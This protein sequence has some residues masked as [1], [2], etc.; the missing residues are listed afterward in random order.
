MRRAASCDGAVS[1]RWYPRRPDL[2]DRQSAVRQRDLCGELTITVA[3]W[4]AASQSVERRPG[5]FAILPNVTDRSGPVDDDGTRSPLASEDELRAERLAIDVAAH[6]TVVAEVAGVAMY[7]RERLSS[8]IGRL[9]SE[10]EARLGPAVQELAFACAQLAANSDPTRPAVTWVEAPPHT[11]FNTT[12]PGGRYAADNPDTIYRQ[13]PIDGRSAYRLE[14]RFVGGRPA[15]SVYQAVAD[16]L[17]PSPVPGGQ[18]NGADLVVDPD[19]TFAITVGPDP[20]EGRVNHLTTSGSAAQLFLRDTLADWAAQATPELAVRRVSG[21]TLAE[22]A[23]LDDLVAKAVHDLRAAGRQ[24]IDFYILGILFEP[25]ANVAPPPVHGAGIYRSSGHF[26]LAAD[27][28]LLVTVHPAGAAYVSV[29]LY[30]VWSVSVSYWS[31]QTSLTGAQAVVGR[32][33][34][35]TF[36]VSAAET[37]V[38]NWLDTTGLERGTFLVRWQDAPFDREPGPSV[39]SRVVRVEDIA[40]A[41][42]PGTT[43]VDAEKRSQQRQDRQRAFTRRIATGAT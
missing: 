14:G 11:W 37:G 3:A 2:S 34:T 20:P 41:L 27:E 19:G 15:S 23:T 18:I 21:P 12:V 33:G 31:R 39:T 5:P 40:A 42:P 10:D 43:Y 13:V 24:W 17:V 30:D 7:W 25:P 29:V 16:P 26:H 6:P 38:H 9:S 35:Y 4:S 1:L 32:D 8:R 22:P 36:V 28:A